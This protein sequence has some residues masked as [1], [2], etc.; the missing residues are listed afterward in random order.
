MVVLHVI[1]CARSIALGAMCPRKGMLDETRTRMYAGWRM[2]DGFGH[3]NNCKYLELFE[4]ARWH[5]GAQK[6][7]RSFSLAKMFPVISGVHVQFLREVPPARIVEIRNRIVSAEGKSFVVRQHMFDSTGRILHAT[8]LFRVTWVDTSPVPRAE[9]PA[10]AAAAGSP[11]GKAGG[12]KIRVLHT[13]EVIRRLGFENPDVARNLIRGA[14]LEELGGEV[15]AAA[16]V[17]LEAAAKTI[18]DAALRV[19][20]DVNDLDDQWRRVARSIEQHNRQQQP[21][22][23]K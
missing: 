8:A 1:R 14:W 12:R 6:G 10:A 11:N 13:D 22:N 3:I 4:L 19:L 20:A 17:N 23:K 7:F 15:P 18:S 5:E 9:T 16:D 21:N 2:V